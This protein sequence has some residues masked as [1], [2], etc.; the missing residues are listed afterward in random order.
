MTEKLQVDVAI[1]CDRWR[2]AVADVEALCRRAAVAAYRQACPFRDRT[3]EV[4][5]VLADDAFVRGLN[6]DYRGKDVPTDVLSFA[7]WEEGD[8]AVDGRALLLGDVVVA[9]ETA[10]ADAA[11]EALPLADR[12]AHLVVH[13]MLHLFGYDHE[14]D[15][16]AER[17]E[18]LESG[19]LASLGVADPYT[20]SAERR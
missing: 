20:V 7:A 13:G 3:A 17:M 6:R 19:V 11:D 5:L 2:G 1:E 15:P 9:F 18:R 16:D 10:S 4:S 8:L 14:A 12:L